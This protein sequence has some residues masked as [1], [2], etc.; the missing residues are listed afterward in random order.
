MIVEIV[1]P[2]ATLFKGEVTSVAVPGVNGEFQMLNNHA[3]IVSLLAKGNVKIV[4]SSIKIAKEFKDKFSKVNEQT[5]WLSINSGTI[6]MNDNKIIV[7]AD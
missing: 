5:F 6:E 3:P 1:S 4:G 2:E 7:L